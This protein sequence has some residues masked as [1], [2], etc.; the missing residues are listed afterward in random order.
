MDACQQAIWGVC[1]VGVMNGKSVP[2]NDY[3]YDGIENCLTGKVTL[4]CNTAIT[5]GPQCIDYQDWAE[6]GPPDNALYVET[7]VDNGKPQP[8]TPPPSPSPL[9]VVYACIK[10]LTR[11]PYYDKFRNGQQGANDANIQKAY[12]L[13]ARKMAYPFIPSINTK[14]SLSE[15][16]GFPPE[17]PQIYVP[18]VYHVF[19]FIPSDGGRDSGRDAC[20]NLEKYGEPIPSQ[21]QYDP[22]NEVKHYQDAGKFLSVIS[23]GLEDYMAALPYIAAAA[24]ITVYVLADVATAG[25]TATT[26]I[27]Q[28]GSVVSI[29]KVGN[30]VKND[31][32]DAI[33]G[34]NLNKDFTASLN[35]ASSGYNTI[36]QLLSAAGS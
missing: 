25:A 24:A 15:F 5:V 8:V 7:V 9:D 36:G 33:N 31:V 17:V 4:Y 21:N 3:T 26:I 29:V 2:Y 12:E 19:N 27:Q 34:K 1:I 13:Q 32:D 6:L 23:A 35:S 10:I 22:K 16:Q 11:S 18:G 14:Y 20:V 30:V 28:I